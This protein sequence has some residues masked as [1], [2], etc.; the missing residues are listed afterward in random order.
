MLRE[1]IMRKQVYSIEYI[2]RRI[3]QDHDKIKSYNEFYSYSRQLRNAFAAH[4][5]LTIL[6]LLMQFRIIYIGILLESK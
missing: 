4:E 2:K 1:Q 3:Q 5:M 6:K